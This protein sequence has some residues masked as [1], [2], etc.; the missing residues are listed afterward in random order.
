[1]IIQKSSQVC[2]WLEIPGHTQLKIILSHNT[3]GGYLQTKKQALV[4]DLFM[5]KESCILTKCKHFR[6]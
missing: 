4:P 5:I 1:M 3:F 2:T 6:L